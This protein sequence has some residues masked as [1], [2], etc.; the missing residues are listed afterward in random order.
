MG[1]SFQSE[2]TGACDL[3]VSRCTA[4]NQE[5]D[6]SLQLDYPCHALENLFTKDQPFSRTVVVEG[7]KFVFDGEDPLAVELA[8]L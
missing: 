6:A 8:K 4:D 2:D 1:G 5:W 7:S 3:F